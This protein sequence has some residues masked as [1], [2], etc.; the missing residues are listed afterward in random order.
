MQKTMTQMNLHRSQVLSD[1]TGKRGLRIIEAIVEGERDPAKLAAL[2][3]GRVKAS[4]DEIV[5]ALSGDYRAEHALCQELAIYN[6]YQQQL[7][8]CEAQIQMHLE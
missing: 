2:V 7:N 3:D 6:T 5:A 8:H 4:P 1:I